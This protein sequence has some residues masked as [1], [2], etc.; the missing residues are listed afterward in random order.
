MAWALLTPVSDAS[1]L[2]DYILEALKLKYH[3]YFW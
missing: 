2:D 3:A 1:L